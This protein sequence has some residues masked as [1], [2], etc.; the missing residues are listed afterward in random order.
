MCGTQCL[1][2]RRGGNEKSGGGGVVGLQSLTMLGCAGKF[3]IV[4]KLWDN[5]FTVADRY[6]NMTQGVYIMTTENVVTGLNV[7]EL[8]L[9]KINEGFARGFTETVNSMKGLVQAAA[10]GYSIAFGGQWWNRV[11]EKS[12]TGKAIRAGK[13]DLYTRLKE[14]ECSNPSVYWAR[15]LVAA[16]KPEPA[17]TEPE[18]RPLDQ[19]LIEEVSKL[20]KAVNK[21]D[22]A[23]I[24]ALKANSLL[25]AALAVFGVSVAEAE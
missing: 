6:R 4:N 23:S 24:N 16:G 8:G 15:I 21:D 7:G 9:D 2:R 20:V 25:I 17:K 13:K 3:D 14:R 12:E 10:D 5:G 22:A 1:S 19:R 18:A 11:D